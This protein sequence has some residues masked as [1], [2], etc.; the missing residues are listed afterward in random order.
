M[1][2]LRVKKLSENAIL[3]TRGSA[4][5]AGY[6]LSRFFPR[7]TFF[8]IFPLIFVLDQSF[9]FPFYFCIS[10]TS[11]TVPARGK[12]LAPTDL[13]FAIPEGPY[14]RIGNYRIS[15]SFIYLAFADNI[16][17]YSIY[18]FMII[19]IVAFCSSKIW[20]G[21]KKLDLCWGPG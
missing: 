2:L 9:V 11:T 21:M 17:S 1:Q 16:D 7:S 15:V 5:A 4:V 12:A 8:F 13:S 19:G 3:P 20:I 18:V 14:A 10:V 6:D